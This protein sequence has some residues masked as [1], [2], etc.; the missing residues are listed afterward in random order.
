M[1]RLLFALSLGLTLAWPAARAAEPAPEPGA[2]LLVHLLDYIGVDYAGAVE[3][4][5]VK[6]E[7]E[8]KEMLEFSAQVSARIGALPA[9]AKRDQLAANAGRLARLVAGKASES[10]VADQAAKIRWALIEAYGLQVA[11]K[12]APD[13]SGAA[14]LYAQHCAGC[15]GASG[16]GDGA[17]AKG[18]DPAPSSFHHGE[19]MASR[20]IYGLYNTVTLGVGST[21]MAPFKQL[22]EHE[23]WSLAFYVAGLGVPPERVEKGE[24]L[25]RSASPGDPARAAFPDYTNLATLSSNEVRSRYG[26][27]AALAQDYLRAHPEALAEGKPASISFAR[28]RLVD[29]LAAYEK[30]DRASAGQLAITAYLDGFELAESSLDA[31]DRDLRLE[32]EREMLALRGMVDSGAAPAAVKQQA[33]RVDALLSAADEKLA[34]GELSAGGAYASSLIILLREGLEA[35]LILAAI[36]AFVARTGR[37]DAMRWVHAGWAAALVMGALTWVAASFLVDVSGANREFT[38]GVTALVAAGMLL[39]VGYWLHGRT[40]AQSWS[41]FLRDQVS[42]ALEKKTLWAMASV[43][44]LAVYRELFEVVLFYQALWIQAGGAG[45]HAVLGGIATAG[46]LLAAFGWGIFKYSLRLPLGPFFAAMTALMVLLAVVFAGQGIAALQE[47]GAVGVRQV[48]FFSL[49]LFGVHPTAE[50]LGAQLAVLAVVALG[51][52]ATRRR[53]A[54]SARNS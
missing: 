28:A 2:Q 48:P 16:R 34:G 15:H 41:R 12:R 6:S 31:V 51:Y 8:Y 33:A 44:F 27:E 5:K 24:S 29:M 45:H 40:Q 10:A 36:I 30:G 46:A 26:V 11:P 13:L 32:I 38:S 37:R 4:G 17:A 43:S 21:A 35:I 3:G 53:D 20:S 14:T 47:A 19:R 52:W 9:N 18:L 25:W 50:T 23:R 54:G 1:K 42:A 49:P 39:Y 22:S 7:D